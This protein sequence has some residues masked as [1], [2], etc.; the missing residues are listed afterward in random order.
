MDKKVSTL[1]KKNFSIR[2]QELQWNKDD[3]WYEP[4]QAH[5]DEIFRKVPHFLGF[6]YISNY[7]RAVSFTGPQACLMEAQFKKGAMMLH[8]SLGEYRGEYNVGVL[9][10]N[11]FGGP[12]PN[13]VVLEYINGNP[14]DNR[15]KNLRVP[16]RKKL[17]PPAAVNPKAEEPPAFKIE[18]SVAPPMA[19]EA[20]INPRCKEVLQFDTHGNYLRK[21]FSIS[22][23]AEAVN[24]CPSS[25]TAC[26][27]KK[28]NTAGEFQWYLRKHP[29]FKNGISNIEPVKLRHREILQY[30]LK[31]KLLRTF[32]SITEAVKKT[33]LPRSGIDQVLK[34]QLPEYRGFQF[35][36]RSD[37]DFRFGV[38]DIPEVEKNVKRHP[39]ART[40]LQFD[41]YGRFIAQY[42]SISDAEKALKKALAANIVA[43]LKNRRAST[44]GFQWRFLDDPYF[45]DGIRDIEKVAKIS[46]H[47]VRSVLQ[48]DLNG[49]FIKKYPDAIAAG[50][51]VKVGRQSILNCTSGYIKRC[52]G[53]QWRSIA[54]PMFIDGIVDIPPLKMPTPKSAKRV[55]K[56]NRLGKL[57]AQYP[58]IQ[59]AA[60]ANNVSFGKISRLLRSPLDSFSE[61]SYELDS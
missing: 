61:F 27:T 12:T 60:D 50:K 24:M 39:N 10:N 32:K 44:C 42:Q 4:F 30:S 8:L 7:G 15:F 58:T 17:P 59:A 2:A 48:F 1:L 33:K 20:T 25:I 47:T 49:K 22:N 45:K 43:C 14:R 5:A 38:R 53:F 54:D 13:D 16:R 56:Y 21:Y 3:K 29:R 57:V 18:H 31:G 23:A 35:R 26:L 11:C 51:A 37:P 6:Y 46:G 41:L 36:Y 28:A 34:G 19:E 9:V 52:R 40:I 55:L